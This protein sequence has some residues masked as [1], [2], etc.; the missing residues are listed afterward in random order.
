MPIV[1]VYGYSICNDI[2]AHIPSNT[3]KQKLNNI[4]NKIQ[5]TGI[6]LVQFFLQYDQKYQYS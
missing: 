1:H 6:Y 5:E 4:N 3:F 2:H